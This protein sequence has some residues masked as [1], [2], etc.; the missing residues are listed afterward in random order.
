MALGNKYLIQ[1]TV[2]CHGCFIVGQKSTKLISPK[3]AEI[4]W[5]NYSMDAP[6]TIAKWEDLFHLGVVL[7]WHHSM[8]VIKGKD[9]S[10]PAVGIHKT[11]RL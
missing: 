4:L 8:F 9:N 2:L 6:L 7:W 11:L 1:N 5:F 3:S 10:H